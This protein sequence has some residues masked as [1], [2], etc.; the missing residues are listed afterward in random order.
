MADPGNEK[1]KQKNPEIIGYLP[2]SV[3]HTTTE[4]VEQRTGLTV[5]V[6]YAEGALRFPTDPNYNV[7]DNMYM[8]PQYGNKY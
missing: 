3:I 8:D 1:G 2:G 6:E 4:Q 5:T 7:G